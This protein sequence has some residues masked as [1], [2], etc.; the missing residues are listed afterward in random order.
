MREIKFRAWDGKRLR[1]DILVQYGKAYYE[2]NSDDDA[3]VEVCADGKKEWYYR[4]W[5]TYKEK[6]WTLEQYTGLKDSNGTEIYEGDIVKVRDDWELFGFMAG[7]IRPIVFK[8]GG[9]RLA[10]AK[11]RA[12]NNALGHWL[13]DGKDVEVIGNIHEN[14]ELL[15]C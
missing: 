3:C 4:D 8:A 5:A 15:S 12:S 7:E 2:Q 13:E 14:P 9:F 1:A 11:G 10:L 6:D